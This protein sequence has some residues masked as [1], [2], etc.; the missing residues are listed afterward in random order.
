MKPSDDEIREEWRRLRRLASRNSL[1]R[2]VAMLRAD[3][4]ESRGVTEQ[5][6]DRLFP[7]PSGEA[8]L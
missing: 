8:G 5:D 4:L 7:H 2:K 3:E 1:G 6:I